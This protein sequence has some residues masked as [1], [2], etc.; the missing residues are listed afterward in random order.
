MAQIA[1]SRV[2]TVV[3]RLFF[4]VSA[5]T[6]AGLGGRANANLAN[7]VGGGRTLRS[8]TIVPTPGAG[9]AG[10]PTC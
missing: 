6:L 1:V 9:S 10:F 3:D 7:L 5:V 8:P 2:S 4:I